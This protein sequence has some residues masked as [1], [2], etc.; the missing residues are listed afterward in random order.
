MRSP[1]D[2]GRPSGQVRCGVGQR[3]AEV[4]VGCVRKLH[5]PHDRRQAFCV[6][7]VVARLIEI[8]VPMSKK[9]RNTVRTS[10]PR[11]PKL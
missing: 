9:L 2:D 10:D 3:G 4:R 7:T 6:H 11:L 8:R 5:A 1:Y